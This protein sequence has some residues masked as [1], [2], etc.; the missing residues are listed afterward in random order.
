MFTRDMKLSVGSGF[1]LVL[2]LL[3]T[4]TIA[5][6]S[7][8]AALNT[9]LERI[10]TQNNVKTE[11]A[12]EMRDALRERVVSMHA[13]VILR[14]DFEKDEEL[15]NF[16]EHGT[17]FIVARDKFLAIASTEDEKRLVN[18]IRD[19]GAQ[20]LPAVLSVIDS[21]LNDDRETAFHVMQEK[22]IP[23]QKSLIAEI[24]SLLNIQ[25]E[26]TLMAAREAHQTYSKTRFLM[27]LLG[28]AAATIGTA[29][30]LIVIR[31]AGRQTLEVEKEKLKYKTLFE[32]NSDG[33]VLFDARGFIDCNPAALK[34]YQ[35]QS[36]EQFI[37]KT[38]ADLGPAFQ[39]EGQPSPDYAREHMSKAMMEGYARFEWI[40][41]R[42]DGS[43][44]T[45]EIALHSMTLDGQVVTQATMRDI[46][47]RKI[48]EE[49]LKAAYDAALEATRL[50]SQFVANVSHEIRT[51]MNGI[52]GMSALMLDTQMTEEQRD[53][54]ETVYSSAE[55]LLTVINDIL[56]FSKIEAGKLE[57]E[58]ID[59]DLRE[60]I[61][62]VAELLAA[63]ADHKDLRLFCQIDRSMPQ[64]VVGDPA[65]IRQVLINLVDNAIKFTEHGEVRIEASVVQQHA[66]DALTV[67][68]AV[69]DSGIG[70]EPAQR[71]RLFKAFSQAD[72]STTRRFGGTGLGL[73]ISQQLVTLMGSAIQV[74]SIPDE[75]STFWFQLELKAAQS[76]PLRPVALT[77]RRILAISPHTLQREIIEQ[78]LTETAAQ[79]EWTTAGALTDVLTRAP[80]PDFLLIDMLLDESLWQAMCAA[81]QRH[82][83]SS[84]IVW[85]GRPKQR[86][87]VSSL[88]RPGDRMV[89]K[90]VRRARLV[91]ALNDA[92]SIRHEVPDSAPVAAEV[93]APTRRVLIVEDNHVNQKVVRIMLGKLGVQTETAANGREAVI[94][95]AATKYDFVLMDCQM[96]EMDGFEATRAIRQREAD[97][98]AERLPIIAM[99]ANA[100]QEDRERCLTEGMDDHLI[101]PLQMF[102]LAKLLS[103][104]CPQR[105][106]GNADP[107]P[108]AAAATPPV[109]EPALLANFNSD[110][111][112]V[113]E[114]L[115]LFRVTTEKMLARLETAVDLHDT[116]QVGRIAHELKGSAAYIRAK[117]LE[118][119]ARE[120]ERAA[121]AGQWALVD[122]R[123][124]RIQQAFAAFVHYAESRSGATSTA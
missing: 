120:L 72:G 78:I 22:V 73:V 115:E 51:P 114:L 32:T 30:A 42:Q 16:Y 122:E 87:A 12:T 50:K 29:V 8:M 43:L 92:R 39:A 13:V 27:I 98:S 54:A 19:L 107:A 47:E 89:L 116:H 5:G 86:A 17:R 2:I 46:T 124:E 59:F 40:G 4:L 88:L 15:L 100:M 52:L 97:Q 104:W 91:D 6:L 11:L 83:P 102:D 84:R 82:C 109:D 74:E 76:L 95:V 45:T 9:R 123:A 58:T 57:L 31:H 36:V 69:S 106:G 117:E 112:L 41:K 103:K 3:V 61:E 81:R 25:R 44:F 75:G 80:A 70:I 108:L 60:A 99:T 93:A 55:S 64:R 79:L 37:N 113:A 68:F 62:D 77:D 111:A 21:A 71:E 67:R 18:L 65:R 35:I 94:A 56:D 101:K 85:L 20:T 14:D 119:L 53:Y 48:A 34:M 10:V 33:I 26:A 49:K 24:D 90:P 1:A 38:P 96:P 63:R 7:Q 121:K 66:G 28:I 105:P 23:A 110:L 118:Q